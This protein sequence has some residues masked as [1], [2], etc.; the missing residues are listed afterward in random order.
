MS[1]GPFAVID[2]ETSGLSPQQG[3][4]AIE[5][6]VS[7]LE[8]G[9]IV[10][11]YQ[12]LMN[13]GVPISYQIQSLTGI[14]QSM[15]DSANPNSEVMGEASKFIGRLPIVAHNASFDRKFYTSELSRI[16]LPYSDPFI[17]TMLI[18]R[19]LYPNSS[20]HKL[21]TLAHLHGIS[22]FGHHRALADAVMTSKLLAVILDDLNELYQKEFIDNRFLLR[23]QKRPKSKVKSSSKGA[24][25]EKKSVRKAVNSTHTEKKKAIHIAGHDLSAKPARQNS[26]SECIDSNKRVDI[27][28]AIDTTE[29]DSDAGDSTWVWWVVGI[30]VVIMLLRGGG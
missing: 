14:S 10:D 12:S 29:S 26:Q 24:A 11:T 25:P 22:T 17:C 21:A 20:N 6:G 28:N 23:Y 18:S 30:V 19:R 9:E 5:I 13:P 16:G 2:F 8:A 1:S 3:D 15:V 7:I 4:R 27:P